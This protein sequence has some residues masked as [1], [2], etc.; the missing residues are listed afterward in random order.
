MQMSWLLKNWVKKILFFPITFYSPRCSS[1]AMRAFDDLGEFKNQYPLTLIKNHLSPLGKHLLDRQQTELQ[2]KPIE[3]VYRGKIADKYPIKL[4]ID[5]I[6]HD[7]SVSGYYWYTKH[8]KL[9][10][11][12]GSYQ[13]N[14]LKLYVR[15]HNPQE[16]KWIPIEAIIG[17]LQN[18][19]FNGTWKNLKSGKIFSL[20]MK[21]N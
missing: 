14:K 13:N 19:S 2:S 9:I 17:T 7:G 16:K 4:F 6:Y 8:K 12:R 3:G 1:H 21:L 11:L 20:H 5:T 15:K 10:E 18:N